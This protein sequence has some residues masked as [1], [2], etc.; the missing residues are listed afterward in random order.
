MTAS[1]GSDA[2]VPLGPVSKGDLGPPGPVVRNTHHVPA[3]DNMHGNPQAAQSRHPRSPPANSPTHQTRILEYGKMGG[4]GGNGEIAG[5]VNPQPQPPQTKVTIAGKTKF[6]I[7]KTCGAIFGTPSFG[8]QKPPPPPHTHA[9][10]LHTAPDLRSLLNP[11]VER[12]NAN[13]SSDVLNVDS[14]KP[15]LLHKCQHASRWGL[16]D[17]LSMVC[18]F[19]F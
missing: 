18:W 11:R 1:R 2:H 14:I 6:T 8:S 13:G 16:R 12:C 19:G 4:M 7:G 5:I 3:A 9:Q 10:R 15:M 17:L